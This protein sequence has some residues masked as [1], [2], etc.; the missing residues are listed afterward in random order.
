MV[1]PVALCEFNKVSGWRIRAVS[2]SKD[3]RIAVIIFGS[4]RLLRL[5]IKKTV[6]A[7]NFCNP[8]KLLNV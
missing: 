7:G 6:R 8:R 4:I 3:K 2:Q 5:P 1:N